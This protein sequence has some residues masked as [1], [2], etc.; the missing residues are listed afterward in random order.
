MQVCSIN[1]SW[2]NLHNVSLNNGNFVPNL[3]QSSKVHNHIHKQCIRLASFCSGTNQRL[4]LQTSFEISIWTFKLRNKVQNEV[5][6]I[7][8]KVTIQLWDQL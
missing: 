8:G 6:N 2:F 5:L 4:C 3:L 1:Y 7:Q